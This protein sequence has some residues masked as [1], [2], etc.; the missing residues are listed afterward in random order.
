[1]E[2]RLRVEP[3]Q[4][5]E[6]GE[7]ASWEQSLL[8][9]LDTLDG[10]DAGLVE[11]TGPDGAKGLAVAAVAAKAPAAAAK[12]LAKL[13][14]AWVVRTGRTVELTLGGDTLKITGA[15]EEQQDRVIEVWLAR[16]TPGD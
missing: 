9:E 12:A 14:H 6:A 4:G 1:M 11:E 3:D 2:L 15:S 13:L 5:E 16:H 8:E 10:V 7:E